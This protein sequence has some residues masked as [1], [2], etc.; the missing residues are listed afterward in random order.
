MKS[1]LNIKFIA[2]LAALCVFT[3]A[4]TSTPCYAEKAENPDAAE[5]ISIT[6]T[7]AIVLTV[8]LVLIVGFIVGKLILYNSLFSI[9]NPNILTF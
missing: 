4:L 3:L 6:P 8:S 7:R 9:G 5:E 2:I 1:A